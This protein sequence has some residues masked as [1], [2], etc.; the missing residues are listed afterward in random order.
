MK[1]VLDIGCGDNPYIAKEDEIVTTVD[2]RSEVKPTVVCDIREL[3]FESKY[4]DKVRASHV[5]EHFG[6]N[7]THKVLDGWVRVLKIGGELEII[8]P[9]IEWAMENIYN[10]HPYD[11]V[12]SNED[13]VISVLYGDQNYPENFHKMGFTKTNLRRE[14]EIFGL[15][16][17][18]IET[19]YYNLKMVGIK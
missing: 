12:I 19:N 6:R 10:T 5:L 14:L 16:I 13:T 7:E 17:R 15:K 3:P 9:N 8:V 4:F 2:I 11:N 1:K 18:H